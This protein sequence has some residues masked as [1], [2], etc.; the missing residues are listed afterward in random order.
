MSHHPPN[1]W[2]AVW[3]S[4]DTCARGSAA[5]NVTLSKQECDSVQA[6]MSPCPNR[7]VRRICSKECDSIQTVMWLCP[8]RNVTLSE[9]E[10]HPVHAGVFHLINISKTSLVVFI[11]NKRSGL[12]CN[13]IFDI[14]KSAHP[15][16]LKWKDILFVVCGGKTG[17]NASV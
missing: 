5:R 8:S 16:S 6:G 7:N 4:A 11:V 9:Q 10:C 2:R 14:C 13:N 15:Y 3:Y 17:G 1:Q 12:P